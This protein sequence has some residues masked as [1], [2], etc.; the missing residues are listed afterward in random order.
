MKAYLSSG[1]R[2]RYLILAGLAATDTA[3]P[4]F[5]RRWSGVLSEHNLTCWCT[6]DAMNM[7]P[8][9]CREFLLDPRLGWDRTRAEAAMEELGELIRDTRAEHFDACTLRSGVQVVTCVVDLDAHAVAKT[10]DPLLR[11]AEAI[12]ANVCISSLLA[13]DGAPG[14]LYL[15]QQ[16]GG[17]T[18]E[19]EEAWRGER[20]TSNTENA[21][22]FE[23]VSHP[24]G[25][26]PLPGLQAADLRVWSTHEGVQ[27]AA[28]TQSPRVN[29]VGRIQHYYG[30]EEFAREA[31]RRVQARLA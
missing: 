25:T 14:V 21:G 5:E 31:S 20:A 9:P 27:R 15:E 1:K 3:W 28:E 18:K 22:H 17:F 6:T 7:G 26:H 8:H 30:A 2:S 16:D 19:I 11:A 24:R 23:I 10:R 29:V 12:C 4:S 13:I